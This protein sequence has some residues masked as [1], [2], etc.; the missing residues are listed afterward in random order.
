MQLGARY[1]WVL[2]VTSNTTRVWF[3]NDAAFKPE[4]YSGSIYLLCIVNPELRLGFI[5]H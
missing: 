4:R 5:M 2:A 1:M 3:F